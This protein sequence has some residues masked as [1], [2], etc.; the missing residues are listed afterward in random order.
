MYDTGYP[1]DTKYALCNFISKRKNTFLF[2]TTFV[3]GE[4]PLTNEQ[5]YSLGVALNNHLKLFP[6]SY[7]YGTEVMRGTV[8]NNDGLIR[9]SVYRKRVPLLFDVAISLA[10]YAGA[11]DGI[12][13]SGKAIDDYPNNK[14]QRL[15]DLRQT[16]IGP[17]TRL[18]YWDIGL[19]WAQPHDHQSF[20]IPGF[21]TAYGED[22]S[23]LNNIPNALIICHVNTVTDRAWRRFTPAGTLT[24]SQRVERINTFIKENTNGKFDS[25]AI[26]EPNAQYT[27]E[28]KRR[29]FSTTTPVNVYLAVSKT[30]MTTFV[31]AKRISDY[32][33]A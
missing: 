9:N 2:L 7:Y 28:D 8:F 6:E 26:V 25:R 15:Y 10:S 23:V 11:A 31:V 33:T 4:E 1:L 22:T 16:F 27:E 3:D 32:A 18:R 20:F 30:V 17:N 29:G 12:W 19:N 14:I 5:E 13:K 24:D 21:N